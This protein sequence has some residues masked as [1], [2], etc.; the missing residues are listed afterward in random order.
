MTPGIDPGA[1]AFARLERDFGVLQWTCSLPSRRDGG[2]GLHLFLRKPAELFVVGSL[3]AYP[4]RRPAARLV[5]MLRRPVAEA[6]AGK[7]ERR[8]LRRSRPVRR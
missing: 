6:D 8:R 4:G 3:D 1:D 5:A 2:G 7:K